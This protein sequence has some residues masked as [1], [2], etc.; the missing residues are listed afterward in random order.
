MANNRFPAPPRNFDDQLEAFISY[1]KQSKT[2][3]V[4]VEI[5]QLETDLKS[6][7]E[8]RQKDQ[9]AERTYELIHRKFME[10]QAERYRRFATALQVVRAANRHNHEVMGALE[11]FKRRGARPSRKKD[12]VK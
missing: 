5:K 11:Q 12:P 7:R 2:T 3:L 4:G 10:G 8:E 6:Q 1:L 9:E